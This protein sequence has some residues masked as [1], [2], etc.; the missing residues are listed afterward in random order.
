MKINNSKNA[1]QG[2]ADVKYLN[3]SFNIFILVMKC[4]IEKRIFFG[5]LL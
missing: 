1:K 4:D 2:G 5:G 3:L